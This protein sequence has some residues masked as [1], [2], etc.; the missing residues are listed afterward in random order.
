MQIDQKTNFVKGEE[1]CLVVSIYTPNVKISEKGKKE[2]KLLPVFVWLHGGAFHK[3]S[4]NGDYH[5][6]NRIMDYGVVMVTMNFRL[7]PLGFM[8]LED[9]ILPGNLGLWDQKMALEW[10]QLNIP[11]YG[12]DPTKVTIA[13]SGA[14]GVS[15]TLHYLS[16][17]SKGLFRSVISFGGSPFTPSMMQTKSPPSY[18]TRSLAARLSCDFNDTTKGILECLSSKTSEG[19]AKS[20]LMFA[21]V[22]DFAPMPFHPI[23]KTM[24]LHKV[25]V[26]IWLKKVS[27]ISVDRFASNPF[28]P[29]EPLE[30]LQSRFFN[31]V[32]LIVGYNKHESIHMLLPL[33]KNQTLLK[34]FLEN[35]KISGPA[36]L[37]NR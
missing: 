23:G 32:P 1:D 36:I 3:G 25:Y 12:G 8:S 10:I 37:F 9:D 17:Q 28:L 11:S 33:L 27:C 21:K 35:W 6:P 14:G 7:G 18:Y 4:G 16:P 22:V 34:Q 29:V 15:A 24:H 26:T 2:I 5:G 20:A 13:G 31:D 19:I 30:A